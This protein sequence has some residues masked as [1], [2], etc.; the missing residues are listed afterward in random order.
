MKYLVPFV[1]LALLAT[2]PAS[3]Q[4]RQGDDGRGYG[5]AWRGGDGR[6]GEGRGGE[7]RG[8]HDN[9]DGRYQRQ[10]GSPNPQGPQGPYGGRGGRSFPGAN[11][12]LYA[13]PNDNGGGQGQGPGAWRGQQNEAREGVR[14][15]RFQSMGEVL[16]RLRQ[17][18]PGQQLDAG[19]SDGPG[20]RP[21]YRVRWAAKDGRLIDYTV[22]AQT[23]AILSEQGR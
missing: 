1:L 20:G 11:G 4:P 22:D 3:A 5:H 17:R 7:G 10:S 15:G 19:L 18:Q 16:S 6:G 13:Q 12:V 2:A 14:E 21:V 9:N 8:Y 23:G